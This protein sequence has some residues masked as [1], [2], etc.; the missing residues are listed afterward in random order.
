MGVARSVS[1]TAELKK[2]PILTLHVDVHVRLHNHHCTVHTCEQSRPL[3]QG[4]EHWHDYL[5]PMCT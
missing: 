3:Q 1:Q 5:I 4:D 2:I